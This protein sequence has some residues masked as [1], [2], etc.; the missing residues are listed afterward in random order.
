MENFANARLIA[1]APVGYEL[2][3]RVLDCVGDC[4]H[5]IVSLAKEFM[6]IA[7]AE[8]EEK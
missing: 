1:A 5:S 8:G 3:Q 7:K 2:A 4:P 6:V